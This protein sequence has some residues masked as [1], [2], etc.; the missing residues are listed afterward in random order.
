MPDHDTN[1]VCGAYK[2]ISRKK[3]KTN[4]QKNDH[5]KLLCITEEYKLGMVNRNTAKNQHKIFTKNIFF[6]RAAP[7]N[8]KDKNAKM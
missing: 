6:S 1:V 8:I 4:L 5:I 7:K 3:K 2:K